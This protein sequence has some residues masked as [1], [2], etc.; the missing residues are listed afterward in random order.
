MT[1]FFS[2]SLSGDSEVEDSE[3]STSQENA[4]DETGNGAYLSLG[5]IS[6]FLSSLGSDGI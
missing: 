3:S 4:W 1:K 5:E 6:G 2:F